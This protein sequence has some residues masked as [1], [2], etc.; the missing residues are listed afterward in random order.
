[1]CD[2]ALLN[3]PYN[4]YL[5][6]EEP[7]N[8]YLHVPYPVELGSTVQPENTFSC[9]PKVTYQICQTPKNK[10]HH[11]LQPQTVATSLRLSQLMR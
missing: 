1:M 10:N 4:L 7:L 8:G 9:I 6:M 3:L 5:L 11:Y 2:I